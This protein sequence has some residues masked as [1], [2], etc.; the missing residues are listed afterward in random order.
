MKIEQITRPEEKLMLN[1]QDKEVLYS[2]VV[3]C[4]EIYEN[5]KHSIDIEQN[6]DDA[7]NAMMWLLDNSDEEKEKKDEC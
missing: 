5:A 6:A 3:L 4:R 7:W 2:A 1:K